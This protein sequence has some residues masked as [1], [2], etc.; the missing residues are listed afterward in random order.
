MVKQSIIYLFTDLSSLLKT[1]CGS[2]FHKSNYLL[3]EVV[4]PLT[5]PDS[6]T[7]FHSVTP[8]SEI[9]EREEKSL[10]LLFVNHNFVDI[11]SLSGSLSCIPIPHTQALAFLH[12]MCTATL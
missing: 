1:A 8:N 2:E 4:F 3:Y 9:V 12:K 7:K 11:I 6:N 5:C 10:Y